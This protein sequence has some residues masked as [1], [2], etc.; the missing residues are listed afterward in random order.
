MDSGPRALQLID[1]ARRALDWGPIKY[2][3]DYP[4]ARGN[5]PLIGHLADVHFELPAFLARSRAELGDVFWIS[6]GR[7]VWILY[8]CGAQSL[9]AL[10]MGVFSN[11]HLQRQK[12]IVLIAGKSLLTQDGDNHRRMRNAMHATFLPR[13]LNSAKVGAR[14][15]VALEELTRRWATQGHA[16]VLR[17]TRDTALSVIFELFGIAR[18]DVPTFRSRYEDLILSNLG[19][20][21]DFPGAPIRRARSAR[22]WIDRSFSSLVSGARARPQQDTLLDSLAQ[23]AADGSLNDEELID[24]LRLVI[25]AGHETIASIM[26][27]ITLR[28]A[29]DGALWDALCA[30]VGDAPIPTTIEEAKRFPLAEAV[31]RETVRM[32]PPFSFT[33]RMALQDTVLGNHSIRARTAVGVDLY[34]AGRDAAVFPRPESFDPTRWLGRTTPP[35]VSELAQFGGG[36][37]FCLGYHLAWLEAVEHIVA[38]VRSMRAAKKRPALKGA[39]PTPRF[40]STEHPSGSTLV[41][42]S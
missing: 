42:F 40:L 34:G 36:P 21:L 18:A 23:P 1:R 19:I 35:T 32:H 8:V 39:L 12:G 30:E 14:V 25:L 24:N 9:Q 5:L 3:G 2:R 20:D 6:L 22:V 41:Q 27:W 38:L 7:R 15:A 10:Q 26:A 28:V 31:F 4:I 29:A 16:Y 17:D 13:G 33:T 37:H 11:T